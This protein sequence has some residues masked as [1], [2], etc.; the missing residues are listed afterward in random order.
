MGAASSGDNPRQERIYPWG[1]TETHDDAAPNFANY[2]ATQIGSTSAAGVF[3]EGSSPYGCED[4]A[5]NVWEWT[6]SQDAGY[7]YVPGDGREETGKVTNSRGIMIRGGA[8]YSD[9]TDVRCAFRFRSYP[10]QVQRLRDFGWWCPRSSL[11]ADP[12]WSLILC[13]GLGAVPPRVNFR[14][15]AIAA[16]FPQNQ[17]LFQL[18]NS[19]S[20]QQ[21]AQGGNTHAPSQKCLFLHARLIC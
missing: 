21:C 14:A 15:C 5:G 8:Y 11:I 13:G 19:D 20:V 17:S 9:S 18:M 1:E 7:P 12:L 6:R 10:L 3:P 2:D 16:K 4:L